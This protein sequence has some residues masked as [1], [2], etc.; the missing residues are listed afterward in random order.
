MKWE[1]YFLRE[2]GSHADFVEKLD[3]TD[4]PATWNAGPGGWI[5]FGMVLNR[6]PGERRRVSSCS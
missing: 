2:L 4:Q 1:G 3:E 6:K 5:G